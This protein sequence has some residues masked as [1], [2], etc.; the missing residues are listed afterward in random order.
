MLTEMHTNINRV[1]FFSEPSCLA[2][3]ATRVIAKDIL[4]INLLFPSLIVPAIKSS[5]T[6]VKTNVFFTSSIFEDNSSRI[7]V[8]IRKNRVQSNVSGQYL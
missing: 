3:S 1:S 2:L 6:S 4:L 5:L 8:D 7:S